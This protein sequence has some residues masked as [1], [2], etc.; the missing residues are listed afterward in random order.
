[1]KNKKSFYQIQYDYNRKVVWIHCSDGSTVGRFNKYTGIDIHHSMSEQIEGKPQCKLC[2]HVK[3][4]KEDWLFFV[5]KAKELWNV[6][7]D[8]N[9]IE[10]EK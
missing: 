7:I 2:T 3:P 1:M 10:Y 5:E 6:D 4:S 9:H 8:K